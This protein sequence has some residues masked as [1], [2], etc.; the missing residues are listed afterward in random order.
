MP[1]PSQPLLS[2]ENAVPKSAYT[3][4][5]MRSFFLDADS[6]VRRQEEEQSAATETLPS[7]LI[8][9]LKHGHA[10]ITAR[11]SA[12]LALCPRL[13]TGANSVVRHPDGAA[14]AELLFVNH[15]D[16]RCPVSSHRLFAYCGHA[17]CAHVRSQANGA[18]VELTPA[19]ASWTKQQRPKL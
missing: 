14:H 9:L 12:A 11:A 2:W 4:T 8:G 19:M 3:R 17:D 10:T 1:L 6:M 5:W 7:S 16:P 18:W 15:K 13:S